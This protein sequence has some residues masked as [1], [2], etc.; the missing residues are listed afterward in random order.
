[1]SRFLNLIE[2]N[3]QNQ[4]ADEQLPLFIRNIYSN[5]VD[6]ARELNDL[7]DMLC[8][9]YPHGDPIVH[10]INE[11]LYEKLKPLLQA[12]KAQQL[13]F[14][15]NEE[16]TLHSLVSM[17]RFLNLDWISRTPPPLRDQIINETI[18]LLINGL[19]RR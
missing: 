9:H 16:A 2:E 13:F 4:K 8:A 6:Y 17:L 15:E 10:K 14:Y 11:L 7:P 19:Q 18:H 12:G 5:L 1:A 3:L